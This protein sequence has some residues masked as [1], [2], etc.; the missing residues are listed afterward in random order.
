[1]RKRVL[2][3]PAI[4]KC[5][6]KTVS[7]YPDGYVAIF[8]HHEIR[9]IKIV[10]RLCVTVL[11]DP[12]LFVNTFYGKKYYCKCTYTIKTLIGSCGYT[13][14]PGP[15]LSAYAITGYFIV[16]AEVYKITK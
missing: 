7:V 12:S 15:F 1:M 10:L 13:R 14:S 11:T 2:L 3:A 16:I 4:R 9:S 8:Y 5:V 6:K